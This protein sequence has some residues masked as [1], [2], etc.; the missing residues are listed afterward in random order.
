MER[1]EPAHAP[2]SRKNAY[3]YR[4]LILAC[5]TLERNRINLSGE[6]AKEYDNYKKME[7]MKIAV[8]RDARNREVRKREALEKVSRV[9]TAEEL[10]LLF[11][12]S[13]ADRG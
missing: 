8:I 10:E 4:L 5:K 12:P 7:E 13:S 2:F 3:L 9:L 11:Y 1:T 6:L